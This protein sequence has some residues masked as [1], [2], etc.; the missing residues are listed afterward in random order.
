[1][2]FSSPLKWLF[3]KTLKD[4][5][6]WLCQRKSF[7]E[8]IREM[9]EFLSMTQ[10]QLALRSSLNPRHIRSLE[11]FTENADPQLSTLMKVA[12][13]LECEL[14]LEFIPKEPIKKLMEDRAQERARQIMKSVKGSTAMEEQQ[15]EDHF[16][17]MRINEFAQELLQ[18]PSQIWEDD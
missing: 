11:S 6:E 18:K 17:E 14:L 15:P 7:S 16:T 8:Q 13:G 5:P 12:D 1:M 4:L 9:R 2:S 3:K 10:G